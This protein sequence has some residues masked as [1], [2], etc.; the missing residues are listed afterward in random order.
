[1]LVIKTVGKNTEDLPKIKDLYYSSFPKNERRSFPELINKRLGDTETFAVY[2]DD[3]FVGMISTM[4]TKEIIHIV[5]L[6]ILKD[7]QNKG[8][9]S[10]TLKLIHDYYQDRKFMVDIEVPNEN[11]ANQVQR[12]KRKSFYLRSGYK[13]TNVRYEWRKENYEILSY[14]GEITLKDYN[15]FWNNFLDKKASKKKPACQSK[16]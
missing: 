15:N 12:I 8:Y 10:K 9:G 5:Y 1:M 4:N 11:S 13:E 3:L 7:Y 6:A 16:K 2:E 14:N